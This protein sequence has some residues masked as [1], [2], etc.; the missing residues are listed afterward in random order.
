MPRLGGPSSKA[1]FKSQ[2]PSFPY[3]LTSRFSLP[4]HLFLLVRPFSTCLP[5]S[6]SGEYR[7]LA[8]RRKSKGSV[9]N[10]NS[11]KDVHTAHFLSITAQ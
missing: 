9:L 1:K 6:H 5:C 11:G 4:H 8:P 10:P 2:A 3:P 7:G